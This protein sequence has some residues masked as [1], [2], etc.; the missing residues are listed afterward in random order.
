MEE[1]KEGI[2]RVLFESRPVSL[3]QKA[4]RTS[5]FN[6]QPSASDSWRRTSTRIDQQMVDDT[7]VVPDERVRWYIST[8]DDDQL[9]DAWHPARLAT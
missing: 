7:S 2:E 4:G 9:R 5:G 6:S 1:T 8:G 3:P